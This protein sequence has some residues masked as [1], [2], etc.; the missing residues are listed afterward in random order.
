MFGSFF[1]A[2]KSRQCLP[3][4]AVHTSDCGGPLPKKSE[5]LDACRGEDTAPVLARRVAR[6]C[7][8]SE[9]MFRMDGV[10]RGGVVRL[11][12]FCRR[13]QAFLVEVL[14]PAYAV[15]PKAAVPKPKT[16]NLV[17]SKSRP[18]FPRF[19]FTLPTCPWEA[20]YVLEATIYGA[21]QGRRHDEP[22]FGKRMQG[23]QNVWGPLPFMFSVRPAP[24]VLGICRAT[25][26]HCS[27]RS[28]AGGGEGSHRKAPHSDLVCIDSPSGRIYVTVVPAL[29]DM[30]ELDAGI[31]NK[32]SCQL[33]QGGNCCSCCC[34]RRLFP[35]CYNLQ[36][37]RAHIDN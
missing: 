8:V 24:K 22:L 17:T 29:H 5:T 14:L 18:R 36:L 32:C 19:W 7:L 35:R 21:S 30:L 12:C 25:P 37:E 13:M 16:L 28:T 15:H 31:M 4:S 11:W 20:E 3:G 23:S 34:F 26:I 10:P 9:G 27:I 6:T 33:Q 2:H 1:W